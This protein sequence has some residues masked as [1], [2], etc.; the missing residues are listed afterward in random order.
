MNSCLPLVLYLILLL[1]SVHSSLLAPVNL[2]IESINFRHVLRWDPG[3]GTPPGT[4]YKI[5]RRVNKREPKQLQ[6]TNGTSFKI[7]LPRINVQYVLT[8]QASYNQSV[9]PESRKLPFKPSIDSPPEVSL[10]GC[11]NCIQINISL[12]KAERGSGI[13]NQDIKAVLNPRF[14]ILWRKPKEAV[15]S[16]IT[17]DSLYNL[18]NLQIG[19][20]YCVKVHTKIN[21]NKNTSPSA[22]NCTFTSIVEPRD[23]S[24]LGAVAA[25]LILAIGVLMSSTLC[26]HYTGFLCK[27]NAL[28]RVLHDALNQGC[29]LKPERTIPDNISMSAGVEKQRKLDNSRTPQ[30][31]TRGSNSDGEDEEEEEEEEHV[32][33]D[34]DVELS[35]GESSCQ[36]SVYVSGNSKMA[37]SGGSGSLTVE[38][39]VPD[40]EF[41]VEVTHG[42]LDRDEDIAEGAEVSLMPEVHVT[43]EADEDKEEV[44]ESSGNINLFSVT[45]ATL[46]VWDEG[47][48][49]EQ[50]TRDSL[51]DFLSDLEP[52]LPAD[53]KWTLSHRDSQT[54]SNDQTTVALML[55]T[56]EDFTATGSEG[57]HAHIFSCD[58]EHEETQEEEEEEDE[59]EEFSGYMRHT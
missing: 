37:A 49:E 5:F 21:W 22:W 52:L 28:P 10:T 50:N 53:S 16:I 48:E 15:E 17:S 29:I 27:Q 30:P 56:Q 47:E 3:P 6:S 39:E 35:S 54:E 11:G 43:V 13:K 46:A 24:V 45:L 18:T 38:T 19:T 14:E 58:G 32:Y 26:L 59:E 9:S 55:R 25:S 7:R 8:V 34:R 20:E 12:P 44:C 33:M 51:A 57:R 40:T 1:D 23:L 4:S 36:N 2:S 41:E 31:A 42:R